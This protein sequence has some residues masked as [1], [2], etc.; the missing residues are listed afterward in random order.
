M[1][2]EIDRSDCYITGNGVQTAEIVWRLVSIYQIV[3]LKS[4]SCAC[5][6]TIQS[7]NF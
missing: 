5:V 7:D 3:T 1:I 2:E 4:L 6:L